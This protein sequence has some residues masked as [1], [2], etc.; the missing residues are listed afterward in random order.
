M[1]A[2]K[3]P[4]FRQGAAAAAALDDPPSPS[5]SSVAK[6]ATTS[7]VE[8]EDTILAK[9]KL[10]LRTKSAQPKSA[11]AARQ[12]SFSGGKAPAS[13]SATYVKKLGR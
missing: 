7:G 10:G 9:R 5:A 2:T 6:P 3:Q 1:A 4:G 11:S 8:R 12:K 13:K